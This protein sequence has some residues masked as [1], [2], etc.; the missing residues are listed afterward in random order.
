[1]VDS[2]TAFSDFPIRLCGCA[3]GLFVAAAIPLGIIAAMMLPGSGAALIIAVAT[4]ILLTGIQLLALTIVGEYVWR[5]L[6]EARRRPPYVIE[7][8]AGRHSVV[9][10]AQ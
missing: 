10:P 9:D 6:E 1:V 8:L 3:G 4:M 7:R 2:I 5:A